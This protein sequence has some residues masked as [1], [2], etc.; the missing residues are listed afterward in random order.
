MQRQTST[1][2]FEGL[3]S[4]GCTAEDRPAP[5]ALPNARQF[6]RA[7]ITRTSKAVEQAVLQR[8]TLLQWLDEYAFIESDYLNQ[9]HAYG[10][11]FAPRDYDLAER[12]R[13]KKRLRE[14]GA[15]FMNDDASISSGQLSG[16]CVACA[17]DPGSK[18]F[19]LSLACNRKCYFCFNENQE[20]YKEGLCLKSDWRRELEEFI[21]Q[22]EHVSYIALTGGEPL[23]Y[24]DETIAFF[25]Y[26]HSRIPSAEL[27]LYTDGDFLD[28]ETARRLAQ[29]GLNEVRISVKPDDP[30]A[31]EEAARRLETAA[32]FIERVMV[33][34]PVEPGMVDRMDA[35][36]DRM[37]KIGAFG[38]NLLE[39]GYP[40]GD[41]APFA[42]RGLRVANPPFAIPYD[43]SYAGGLPVSGSEL[44]CLQILEHAMDH[45]LSLGVHYCSLENKNRMQICQM[46]SAGELD[47]DLWEWDRGNFFWKTVKVFDGDVAPVSEALTAAGIPF[48]E[49]S[50]E[51]SLQFHP[52]HLSLIEGLGAIPALSLNILKPCDGEMAVREVALLLDADDATSRGVDK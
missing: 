22:T 51:A 44:A 8:P 46:N 24:P 9:L 48:A 17:S 33:E 2:C 15:R 40:M 43:Y 42:Q 4:A 27:R 5:C 32:Q 34:M 30:D 21:E 7:D 38:I 6:K 26:A 16:A 39:L 10:I 29:A 31:F 28:E 41:W 12:E 52:A 35:F 23:L 19:Y 1:D 18:T 37:E 20:G 49:D 36:L 50:Q 25:E 45:G 13:I 14:K 3:S 11:D 47:A